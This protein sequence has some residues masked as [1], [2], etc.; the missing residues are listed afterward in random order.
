LIVQISSVAVPQIELTA[1]LDHVRSS[2][3]PDYEFAPGLHSVSLL[4]RE[5]VAYVE[6]MT[7]SLWNSEKA[8]RRFM[9]SRSIPKHVRNDGGEI[10]LEKRTYELLFSCEGR[11]GNADLEGEQSPE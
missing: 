7:V 10:Q 2:E 5:C 3:I 4:R 8:L 6:V 9:Q 1:Y 11:L